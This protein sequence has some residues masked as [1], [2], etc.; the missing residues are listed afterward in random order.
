MVVRKVAPKAMRKG[1]A[2]SVVEFVIQ[3][4]AATAINVDPSMA[5]L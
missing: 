1:Y 5:L 2:T 3:L 4:D